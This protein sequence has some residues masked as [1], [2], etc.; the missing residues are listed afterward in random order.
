MFSRLWEMELSLSSTHQTELSRIST[1]ATTLILS[2]EMLSERKALDSRER[3]GVTVEVHDKVYGIT[4]T[5]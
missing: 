1:L 5:G 4:E 2:G 3:N